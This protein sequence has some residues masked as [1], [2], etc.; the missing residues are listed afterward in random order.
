MAKMLIDIDEELLADAA[1]VFGTKTKKD[2]V[3]TALRESAAQRRRA[4]A[5]AKLREFGD[6]GYFDELLDKKNYRPK[7]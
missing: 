5:L 7:P 2:T 3:N 4:E 1:E 6:A